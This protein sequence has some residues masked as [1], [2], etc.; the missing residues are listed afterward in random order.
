MSDSEPIQNYRIQPVA[1]YAGIVSFVD[2]SS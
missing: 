1:P 2:R